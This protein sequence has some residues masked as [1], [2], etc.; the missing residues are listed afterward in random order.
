[1]IQP[2]PF[3]EDWAPSYL[4]PRG[5]ANVDKA[6]TYRDAQGM[7]GGPGGARVHGGWDIFAPPGTPVRSPRDGTVVRTYSTD[8]RSGPVY[9][10]IVAI[11]FAGESRGVVFRHV[12]PAPGIGSSLS[13]KEGQIVGYVTD[14]RDGGDHVHMEIH[15]IIGA[16]RDYRFSNSIDPG[17]Y[18]WRKYVP[19]AQR[20]FDQRLDDAWFAPKSGDA[21]RKRLADWKAAGSPDGPPRKHDSV[22][23]RR[24]RK[25]GGFGINA[26]RNIVKAFR[27][28]KR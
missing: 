11:Q 15:K 10:G 16:G 8:D 5:D 6:Y 17:S 3:R 19:P 9:G 4:K 25:V 12:D 1:M 23:Y 2:V 21:V 27:P 20:S 24:L 14:W 18:T 22:M 7:P 28:W 13:V 26:S